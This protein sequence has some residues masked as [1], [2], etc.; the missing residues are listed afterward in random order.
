VPIADRTAI[1]SG[2]PRKY[3]FSAK[4]LSST[5]LLK[6]AAEL[7]AKKLMKRRVYVEFQC[8][9]MLPAGARPVWVGDVVHLHGVGKIRILALSVNFVRETSDASPWT[10]RP[11][12]YA[13]ELI[14]ED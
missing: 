8:Q 5:A 9:M 3:A 13:G 10:W 6:R 1:W 4:E 11:A 12:T 14:E 7:L 2:F